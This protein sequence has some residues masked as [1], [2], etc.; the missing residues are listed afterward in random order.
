MKI[1][2]RQKQKLIKMHYNLKTENIY[3]NNQIQNL[4]KNYNSIQMILK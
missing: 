2:Y 3:K 4:N 1:I